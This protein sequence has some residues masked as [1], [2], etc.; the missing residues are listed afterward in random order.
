[1]HCRQ[2]SASSVVDFDFADSEAGAVLAKN[3]LG[4]V[5]ELQ[6]NSILAE[7]I[8]MSASASLLSIATMS[9]R[10]LAEYIGRED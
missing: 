8:L 5:G 4:R 2:A 9:R 3:K 7:R 6:I 10:P 1:M